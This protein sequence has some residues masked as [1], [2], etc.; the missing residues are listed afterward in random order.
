MVTGA[1]GTSYLAQ[2]NGCHWLSITEYIKKLCGTWSGQVP[3]SGLPVPSGVSVRNLSGWSWWSWLLAAVTPMSKISSRS[4]WSSPVDL[5]GD[6]L[7]PT[8]ISRWTGR[9]RSRQPAAVKTT[10]IGSQWRQ[11]LVLVWTRR[12]GW[13]PLKHRM[14]APTVLPRGNRR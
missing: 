9:Q 10:R 1:V 14:G 8:T 13:R 6:H 3:Y 7:H 4:G 11:S 12:C 2:Y 5:I